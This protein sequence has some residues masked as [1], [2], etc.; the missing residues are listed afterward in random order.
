M[1]YHVQYQRYPNGARIR[2]FTAGLT[3][4]NRK[5]LATILKQWS[6]LG[7]PPVAAPAQA[8]SRHA[9]VALAPGA[10]TTVLSGVGPGVL[11]ALSARVTPAD[12]VDLRRIVL[13]VYWDGAAR[14]AIESP[15]GD[16]FGAGFGDQRMRALPCA[17]T[18]NGYVCYWPMP[19]RNAYRVELENTGKTPA[20][21]SL[22]ARIAPLRANAA[23]GL[24]PR[25]WRQTTVSGEPFH[26]LH[27]TGREL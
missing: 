16:F 9:G 22:D 4:A 20:Y 18:D 8:R 15:I 13:R 12:R 25:S 6:R 23:G 7:D 19:F 3:S 21:I 2:T 17:M 5:A 1:Y 26:I 27:V 14:P 10:R 24:L 11:N